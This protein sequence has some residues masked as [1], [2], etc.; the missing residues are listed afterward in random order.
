MIASDY[1]FVLKNGNLSY[2]KCPL[3]MMMMVINFTDCCPY[4]VR[5]TRQPLIELDH[6]RHQTVSCEVS[7]VYEDIPWEGW[8]LSN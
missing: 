3:E 4:F 6:L 1:N 8:V 5:E 7:S 2:E